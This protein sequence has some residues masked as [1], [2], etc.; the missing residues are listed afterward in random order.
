MNNRLGL[1]EDDGGFMHNRVLKIL[2]PKQPKPSWH[3]HL[4]QNSRGKKI[5]A[6][7]KD[8]SIPSRDKT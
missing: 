7:Y 5:S 2:N 6:F 3:H 4:R 8:L 1:V